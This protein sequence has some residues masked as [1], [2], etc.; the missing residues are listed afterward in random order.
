MLVD[1]RAIRIRLIACQ[2]TPTQR[3][4]LRF[5]GTL[6][7]SGLYINPL[8]YVC[9]VIS[10]GLLVDFLMHI[11]LRYYESTEA[12]REDKVKDTLRTM[13]ASILVGGLSTCL[14]VIPLAFASSTILK[15]V[16]ISFIAMVTLGVGHGLIL[17]PVLLSC[18][19]PTVSIHM[20]HEVLANKL[21]DAEKSDFDTSSDDGAAGSPL[22]QTSSSNVQL[23]S[24]ANP[25][26]CKLNFDS[27]EATI[28]AFMTDVSNT[29]GKPVHNID[30]DDLK[31]G[32]SS[33]REASNSG[34]PIVWESDDGL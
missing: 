11:I 5:S 13:G 28:L 23:M 34:L 24:N 30:R 25:S 19:G 21:R 10:I 33:P 32:T 18:F 1:I 26:W 29:P 16:F 6:H 4:F 9:L 15:T 8:V 20:N 7:F 3:P 14:G 17:L 2:R 27:A 12:T 22:S 31:S